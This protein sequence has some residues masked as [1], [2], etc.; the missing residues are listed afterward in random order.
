MTCIGTPALSDSQKKNTAA[1]CGS[2]WYSSV[3]GLVLASDQVN[4]LVGD[5]VGQTQRAPVIDQLFTVY[6]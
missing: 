2:C 4:S 5:T 6:R 3:T 1:Y